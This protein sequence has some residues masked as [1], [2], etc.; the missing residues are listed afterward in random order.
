MT[1]SGTLNLL[2][3][4]DLQTR[5]LKPHTGWRKMFQNAMW[6][7]SGYVA[8]YL[9]GFWVEVRG[10]QAARKEAPV[11]IVA[12]HSS[13]LDVFTIA[14]CFASPVARIENKETPFLWAPQ[15]IGHTIFVN[16]LVS[17][18][19]TSTCFLLTQSTLYFLNRKSQDSRQQA[20]HEITERSLSPEAWPQVFV[21]AEG[22]TT[23]AT[24]L[25]RFGTGGFRPGVPVQPV[26]VRY[27]NREATVWTREQSHRLLHSLLL[28]FASP[29]NKVTLE[30]LPVY[31]PSEEEKQDSIL[32]ANNVQRVMA[33]SLQI[34]AT[35]FQRPE[36]INVTK[37]S[38]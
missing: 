20:S 1:L 30:F 37:K 18:K 8:F 24:G 32:F 28:I 23:N 36:F 10:K 7:V 11:L 33:E 22:T 5:D 19:N 3:S 25:A 4:F 6:I 2:L 27:S 38:E 17:I 35:D 13:F 31:T 14:L 34:P 12:P 15:A 16:R 21:F 9:L 26:T 29:F